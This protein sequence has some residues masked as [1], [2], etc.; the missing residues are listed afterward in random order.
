MKTFNRRTGCLAALLLATAW[1]SWWW[2]A[3]GL[4]EAK[5]HRMIHRSLP[6]GST[7]VEVEAWIDSL[8]YDKHV[9]VGKL[10]IY[11][12]F[13]GANVDL[14][15]PGELRVE[16]SFDPS[17]GLSSYEVRPFTFSL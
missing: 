4:T 17:G 3:G 9:G 16:C 12:T 1:A 7:M 10:R 8:P 11:V 5:L 6:A 13:E 15:L 2:A 14:L